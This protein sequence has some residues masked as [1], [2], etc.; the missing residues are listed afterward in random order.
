MRLVVLLI[1][2]KICGAFKPFSLNIG[3]QRNTVTSNKQVTSKIGNVR[4]AMSTQEP[5]HW[6]EKLD[7]HF[8]NNKK[9]YQAVILLAS[10]SIIAYFGSSAASGVNFNEI[11]QNS[12]E[13]IENLGPLGPFYFA[14]VR[15]VQITN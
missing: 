1:L 8:K 3:S 6:N 2:A 4:I 10:I 9:N 7:L 5:T 14:M 13:K 15:T 11:L 12:I